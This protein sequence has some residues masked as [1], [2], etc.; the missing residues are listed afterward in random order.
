MCVCVRVWVEQSVICRGEKATG[1][2]KEEGP[3]GR[4][5]E[6]GGGGG[7]RIV[8]GGGWE[9]VSRTRDVYRIPGVF[10]AFCQG[11]RAT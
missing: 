11:C 10:E 9:V 1:R 7:G 5:E 3:S 8:G 6:W 4:R 2:Q